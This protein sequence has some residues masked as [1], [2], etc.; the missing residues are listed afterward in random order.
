MDPLR[1]LDFFVVDHPHPF[2]GVE[3][4][5]SLFVCLFLLFFLAK[6]ERRFSWFFLEERKKERK[7]E[8][9]LNSMNNG[10]KKEN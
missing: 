5:V 7:K 2:F 3:N 8:F 9:D 10:K 4:G 1:L 6:K